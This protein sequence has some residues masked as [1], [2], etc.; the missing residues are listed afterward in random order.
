MS[1]NSLVFIPSLVKREFTSEMQTFFSQCL[2]PGGCTLPVPNSCCSG[3][4]LSPTVL[5]NLR[6]S[7]LSFL[8]SHGFAMFLIQPYC[9]LPLREVLWVILCGPCCVFVLTVNSFGEWGHQSSSQCF[10]G[11]FLW[12]SLLGR[13]R[14]ATSESPDGG[15]KELL[16][17]DLKLARFSSIMNTHPHP[18]ISLLSHMA[19]FCHSSL[20]PTCDSVVSLVG[21]A[22]AKS[23]HLIAPLFS[24]S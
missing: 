1:M 17:N 11:L 7:A 2:F 18:P 23:K 13:Q 19:V 20:T 8:S 5:R 6:S 3:W 22:T 9:S 12:V 16:G 15:E 21:S 14:N 10:T 24:L 4:F